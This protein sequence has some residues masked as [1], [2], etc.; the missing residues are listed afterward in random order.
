MGQVRVHKKC[1]DDIFMSFLFFSA[2][3]IFLYLI[4]PNKASI[5]RRQNLSLDYTCSL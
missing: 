4:A 3:G 2:H 5:H 1:L